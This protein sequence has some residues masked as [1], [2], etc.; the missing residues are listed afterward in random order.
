MDS[1]H[2][3]GLCLLAFTLV[4]CQP[5]TAPGALGTLERDRVELTATASEIIR[6]LPLAEGSQVAAGD[7]L[8]QL[9]DS[10]QQS[11][12]AE[13]RSAE[14]A[15]RAALARL[16][17][18][19]RPEDIAA[20]RADRDQAQANLREGKRNFTR[21]AQLVRQQ[22]MSPADLDRAR[23]ERD[24]ALAAWQGAEQRLAKLVHGGRIEDIEEAQA[25][26]AATRARVALA[27]QGLADLSV[28]A[29]RGGRLD[30]L[31]YQL[32]ERVAT[33]A[34]LARLLA[35]DGPYARVYV[36]EPDLAR[37]G[38]GL[39]LAVYVDGV[40]DPMTGS[41][42]WI[43]KDPAF[44]PYYGLNELDRARLVYLAKIDLPAAANLLPSGIPLRVEPNRVEPNDE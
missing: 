14:A 36:P 41:L 34:V 21:V 3:G 42:R 16:I 26:L 20:A 28:R 5:T 11:V 2:R 24:G 32:G 37:Y 9:D 18:G 7:L 23:A 35:E 15:A 25:N 17:N 29:P 27:A 39:G 22:L 43:A 31:P 4:G 8:V 19:E 44:T 10:R 30:S 13:A 40:A 38:P 33:G 1:W 6:A 12:L